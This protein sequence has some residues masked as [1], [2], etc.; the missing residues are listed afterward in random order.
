MARDLAEGNMALEIGAYLDHAGELPMDSALA[1]ATQAT[2]ECLT[3]QMMDKRD[4]IARTF[5]DK[6]S[7]L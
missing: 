2:Q 5:D 4:R 1:Q 3:Q 7:T 6:F